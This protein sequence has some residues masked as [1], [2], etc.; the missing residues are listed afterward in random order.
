MVRNRLG[1]DA[2]FDMLMIPRRIFHSIQDDVIPLR[3]SQQMVE[4]LEKAG[5]AVK[6]TRYPDL[7]HDCWSAAYND[8]NVYQWMLGCKRTA[9]GDDVV[10]PEAN[11]STVGEK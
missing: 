6:F 3:A 4:A 9:K 1:G 2:P 8:I 5:A 10:V 11:K 7:L